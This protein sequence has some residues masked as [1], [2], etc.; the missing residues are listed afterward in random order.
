MIQIG[1]ARPAVAQNV[2]FQTFRCDDGTEFVAAFFKG[3]SSASVQLDGKKMTLPHRLL[4]LSGTRYSGG[5]VTLRIKAN[6]ATLSR[7]GRST[8]CSTV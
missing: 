4:S 5:G 3:T 8:D 1:A 2:T 6:T 7:G